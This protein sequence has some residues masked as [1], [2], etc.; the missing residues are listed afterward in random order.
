MINVRDIEPIRVRLM[1][2]GE[3]AGLPASVQLVHIRGGICSREQIRTQPP[4][5]PAL[6]AN[7]I[8]RSR[9]FDYLG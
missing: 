8:K 3:F 9:A 6:S 4:R 1:R 5:E 2:E 7:L